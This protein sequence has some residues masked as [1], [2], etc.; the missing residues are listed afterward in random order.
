M[1]LLSEIKMNLL[2]FTVNKEFI[3]FYTISVNS[4]MLDFAWYKAIYTSMIFVRLF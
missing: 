4:T 1:D 2:S 3:R